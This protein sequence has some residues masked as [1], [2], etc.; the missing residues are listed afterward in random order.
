MEVGD[1][2]E[3]AMEEEPNGKDV[4][5]C[6]V[7]NQAPRH[8]VVQVHLHLFLQRLH[9]MDIYRIF[10]PRPLHPRAKSFR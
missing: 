9:Y 6:P 10:S 2:M 7:V 8:E 3:G 5:V 1:E 4:L